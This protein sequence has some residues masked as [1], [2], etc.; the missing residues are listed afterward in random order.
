MSDQACV[1]RIP[2]SDDPTTFVLVHVSRSGKAPLDLKLVA[3]EGESPY[4]GAGAS[5]L[6]L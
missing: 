6:P 3:T 5:L 2:R 4:V 1:L